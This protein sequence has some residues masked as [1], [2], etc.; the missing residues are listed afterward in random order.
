MMEPAHRF[1]F[2]AEIKG[3][4]PDFLK[5]I[6]KMDKD[7]PEVWQQPFG[8]DFQVSTMNKWATDV[9]K[10][11]VSLL[12]PFPSFSLYGFFLSNHL[13]KETKCTSEILI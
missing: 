12:S 9:L 1:F 8:V 4:Q 5:T 13:K 7:I 10:Q 6:C 3:F 11:W 2:F